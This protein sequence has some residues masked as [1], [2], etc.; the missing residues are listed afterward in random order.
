[1]T[2]FLTQKLSCILF[3]VSLIAL[4][5]LFLAPLGYLIS[6]I[7]DWWDKLQHSLAFSVLT[8][9]GLI[10]YGSNQ[11]TVKRV[12]LILAIYGA[13]IEVSQSL[14]GWRYGEFR[15][16]LADL[17]GVAIAWGIFIYLQKHPYTSKYLK[18]P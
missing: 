4:T 7:F 13:L 14:S 9:L 2:N 11:A 15:D 17:L 10:A 5:Y 1:M 6:D 8:I 18:T 3:W 12:V 16:W